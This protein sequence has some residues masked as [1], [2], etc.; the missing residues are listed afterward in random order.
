MKNPD[1]LRLKTCEKPPFSDGYPTL[2]HRGI[3]RGVKS[4]F[5]RVHL[6]S[7]WMFGPHI[8]NTRTDL[9]G[10]WGEKNDINI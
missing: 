8:C 5:F 10:L 2:W 3:D 9:E 7:T 6:G 4:G 1:L